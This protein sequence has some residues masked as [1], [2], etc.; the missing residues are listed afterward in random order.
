MADWQLVTE[1]VYF[2]AKVI[3]LACEI[4]ELIE[5]EGSVALSALQMVFSLPWS[6][7]VQL[8]LY[9]PNPTCNVSNE[10]LKYELQGDAIPDWVVLDE[11]KRLIVMETED[12]ELFGT[13]V[14]VTVS[15]TYLQLE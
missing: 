7:E 9:E 4:I 11:D 3:V 13:A 1:P 12:E 10:D 5:P 6:K 2:E 14:T 8:P 15:V